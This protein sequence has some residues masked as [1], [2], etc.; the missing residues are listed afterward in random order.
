MG[1]FDCEAVD[2]LLLSMADYGDVEQN[3]LTTAFTFC[4]CVTAHKHYQQSHISECLKKRASYHCDE[5]YSLN[6]QTANPC[7]VTPNTRVLLL[8]D[9]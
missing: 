9:S 6:N 1:L 2:T 5:I 7:Y 8:Y 4:V 3:S